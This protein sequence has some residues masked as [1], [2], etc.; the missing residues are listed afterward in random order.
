MATEVQ[1]RNG[2]VIFDGQFVTIQRTGFM[3]RA[4]LGKGEK[5]IPVASI[6]AVEQPMVLDAPEK[7]RESR[8]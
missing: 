1:G 7:A 5:R 2:T 8:L 4:T 6:T 3:A